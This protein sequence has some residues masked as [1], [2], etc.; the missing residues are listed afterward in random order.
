MIWFSLRSFQ[1]FFLTTW[2]TNTLQK[3]GKAYLNNAQCIVIEC[4]AK[5][6]ESS[7]CP[8]YSH[9]VCACLSLS[10]LS[11]FRSR[12]CV[13]KSM[14]V[15]N[16]RLF[17]HFQPYKLWYQHTFTRWEREEKL[18]QLDVT[19][20]LELMLQAMDRRCETCL[21]PFFFNLK[22][23]SVLT[24]S[25]FRNQE[26]LSH[27]NS[28]LAHFRFSYKV[29]RKFRGERRGAC[30]GAWGSCIFHDKSGVQH[31]YT[32]K[33]FGKG[34]APFLSNPVWVSFQTRTKK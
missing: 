3:A 9:S 20:L 7:T 23:N 33:Y 24:E 28:F 11:F 1:S 31:T 30:V 25:L 18:L 16:F 4:I 34:M 2:P 17:S 22:Q 13:W 27:L 10:S 12:A 21:K 19:P 26:F 5:L 32:R 14:R 8:V 6:Q 29:Y 15:R